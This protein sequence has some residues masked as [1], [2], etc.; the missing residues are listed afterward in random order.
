MKQTKGGFTAL[1]I[2]LVVAVIGLGALLAFGVFD[3]SDIKN[4]P[5][6]QQRKITGVDQQVRDLN[7]LS[8]SD[9][10]SAIEGDLNSTNLDDLDSEMDEVDRDLKDI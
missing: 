5:G 1:L 4:I 7:K 10:V 8:S 6:Y 3:V 9:E 2:I